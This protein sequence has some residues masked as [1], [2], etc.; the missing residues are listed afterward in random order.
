MKSIVKKICLIAIL[1][2]MFFT[3]ACGYDNQDADYTIKNNLEN[4]QS[5]DYVIETNNNSQEIEL[6]PEHNSEENIISLTQIEDSPLT[7]LL[8]PPTIVGNMS[9]EEALMNRRS[10][11]SFQDTP[12]TP[13][14][15]SQVLW[16]AYGVSDDRGFRTAPSAGALFP[17]EIFVV[18]GD[19]TGVEIGVYRYIPRE[20]KI[21]RTSD[22]D[23]REELGYLAWGQTFIQDAPIIIIYTAIFDRTTVRYGVE[24]GR[25]YVYM[26]VGHSAQ[27][28][29]LQVE[30]LGLGTC[31]VGAFM[32]NNI[33]ALLGLPPESEEELL[34]LMPVGYIRR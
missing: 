22:E 2:T 25:V 14:Q 8:P 19:V 26:E 30:S 34:Y 1:L 33:N 29:Y 32:D 13:E 27:N 6:I 12:L 3:V 28:V 17:L 10:H 23:I 21:V 20:H 16:A 4:N 31:A 9:V 24:Q 18:V 15:L 5:T 7:Y 11:R